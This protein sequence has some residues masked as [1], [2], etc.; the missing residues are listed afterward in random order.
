[1]EADIPLNVASPILNGLSFKLPEQRDAAAR[2][3][4]LVDLVHAAE[5]AHE[6]KPRHD[7]SGTAMGLPPQTDPSNHPSGTTPGL[8][9][10]PSG[11][12]CL[13]K[14]HRRDGPSR[15]SVTA[16]VLRGL[17][18]HS[19]PLRPGCCVTRPSPHQPP[20]RDPSVQPK[21]VRETDPS[22]ETQ[23][24]PLD[25]GVRMEAPNVDSLLESLCQT[26][27]TLQ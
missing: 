11:R 7:L 23:R 4:D 13:G 3:V 21:E 9:G 2:G 22:I 14:G 19:T 10:S 26:I 17:R 18:A 20:C 15:R 16:P 24:G 12:S 1:M 6:T 8:I 27:R 25:R 5:A